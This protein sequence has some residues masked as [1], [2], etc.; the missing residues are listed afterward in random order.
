MLKGIIVDWAS[1]Q[2]AGLKDALGEER[3]E[4]LLRGCKVR[5]LNSVCTRPAGIFVTSVLGPLYESSSACC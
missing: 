4:E 1:A 2:I 5:M 3:A